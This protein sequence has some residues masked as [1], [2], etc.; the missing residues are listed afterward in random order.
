M[1]NR[2]THQDLLADEIDEIDSRRFDIRAHGAGGNFFQPKSVRVLGNLLPL[3][4]SYLPAA[5][6]SALA[7]LCEIT[8]IIQNPFSGL[9]IACCP[10]KAF[11]PDKMKD[12]FPFQDG[13]FEVIEKIYDIALVYGFAVRHRPLIVDGYFS[14]CQISP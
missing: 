2:P 5:R 7:E 10:D 3:D 11:A 8:R 12:W 4:Q 6:A 9:V 14:Q 1:Q 13:S